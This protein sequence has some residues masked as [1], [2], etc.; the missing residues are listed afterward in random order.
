MTEEEMS[1][2]E[3]LQPGDRAFLDF[4]DKKGELLTGV[5]DL[6][7]TAVMIDRPVRST[8]G[9]PTQ[10]APGNE[11]WYVKGS[12]WWLRHEFFKPLI[13]GIT[14]KP[15]DK[16]LLDFGGEEAADGFCDEAKKLNGTIVTVKEEHSSGGWFIEERDV[17]FRYEMFNPVSG[18]NATVENSV[19]CQCPCPDLTT[20]FAGG[21]KFYHCRHCQKERLS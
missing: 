12:G 17:W 13:F 18:T 7:K 10:A 1:Y 21:K 20:N 15:G 6:D 4:G 16:A 9:D 2:G 5:H 11:G 8:P 19:Y 3:S 14:L